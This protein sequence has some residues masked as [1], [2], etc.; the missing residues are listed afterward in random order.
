M[1]NVPSCCASG[2][3]LPR[4]AESDLLI[5]VVDYAPTLLGLLGVPAR[6]RCSTQPGPVPAGGEETNG[7]TGWGAAP[8]SVYLSESVVADQGLREGIRPWRG[9]HGALHLR[10]RPGRSWCCTTTWTTLTSSATW[11]GSRAAELRA[12]LERELQGWMDRLD[13]P[14]ESAEDHLARHGLTEA[15]AARPSPL[16]RPLTPR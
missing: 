12:T 13:D 8:F 3:G 14:L 2:R 10:P 5:G 4:G 11:P 16:P 9:V 7:A 1:V 15:W 6:R